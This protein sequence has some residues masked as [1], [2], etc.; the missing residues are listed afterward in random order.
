MRSVQFSLDG[1]ATSF[2]TKNTVFY[3]GKGAEKRRVGG[4]RKTEKAE[5]WEE[6]VSRAA[7]E[8]MGE[9]ELFAGP[10]AVSVLCEFV[11]PKG[12]QR[13]RSPGAARLKETKPDVDKVLRLV[14]D[15]LTG[16]VFQDDSQ[17]AV[18]R[19]GKMIAGQ[20]ESATTSVSVLELDP[21]P[22]AGVRRVLEKAIGF[23][24]VKYGRWPGDDTTRII[25]DAV[26]RTA[27]RLPR[28]K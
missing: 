6:R 1:D 23:F 19:I 21:T 10:V 12:L 26:A 5:R 13:K 28:A 11:M 24:P 8:R 27:R 7:S 15:G 14:L 25:M 2:Q 18:A 9:S 17:V 4:T 20:G 22:G 3:R 16:V